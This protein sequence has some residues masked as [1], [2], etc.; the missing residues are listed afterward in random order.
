MKSPTVLTFIQ[1]ALWQVLAYVLR[2]L[3]IQ[4]P[5][6]L[7]DYAGWFVLILV[8]DIDMAGR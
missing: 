2:V 6:N 1:S 7:G 5:V 3:S 8:C 4:N